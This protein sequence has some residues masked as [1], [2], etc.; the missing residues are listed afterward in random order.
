MIVMN[1][2]WLAH[3]GIL[4]QKWGIRRYENKDGTLTEAGKAR[5]NRDKALNEKRKKDNRI[6]E[7]GLKDANRMIKEDYQNEK[8]A[9]E[10]ARQMT[11]YMKEIE[12][13]TNKPKENPRMDLSQM[14][15]KELRDKINREL[16]E[17][18]YNNVFNPPTVSRGREFVKDT[19]DIAGGVLGVT[20]S[21]LGIALAIRQLKDG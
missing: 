16:L 14:S 10:Q 2:S 8:Q 19:L 13:A 7:E 1:N 12:R 4:G 11:N 20:A 21:A 18:Q 6:P 9:L 15:D 5:Y 17:R 3:H